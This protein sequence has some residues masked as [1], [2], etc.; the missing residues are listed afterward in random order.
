MSDLY[1]NL[2]A[3]A[4]KN[5]EVEL[6]G[7]VSSETLAR[8]FM[9]VLE[10][11]Q[12]EF[13][14]PGF[15]KGK[16]PIDVVRQNVHEHRLLEEAAEHALQEAY[17]AIVEE[18]K[19][20]VM[21]RPEVVI[22]K[23]AAGNP[24]EF[25]IR[26]GIRPDVK[27]PNYKKIAGKVLETEKP[28]E[29]SDKEL[30]EVILTLRKMRAAPASEG[31]S[32]PEEEKK[33]EDLPELTDEF[34]KTLG[35]FQTV[36]DFKTKLREN[37]R[38]EKESEN[39][40][41]LREKIAEAL[42]AEAKIELPPI[43]LEDEANRMFQDLMADLEHAKLSFEDYLKRAQKSEDDIKKEQRN[44]VERQLKMRFIL[45]GIAEAEHIA[46]KPEDIETETKLMADRYPDMDPERI[47]NYVT[48]LLKNEAVM[49][50]LEK[51]E[52]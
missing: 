10:D 5:S 7:E 33:T 51:K 27:L 23:L 26:V 19:L 4:P 31:A 50:L 41:A 40:T 6:T 30:E 13:E 18:K 9:A 20:D 35:D 49:Q 43:L 48:T 36:D 42:V 37:M 25:K 52:G 29:V 47:E 46:P 24:L 32:Q 21:G 11:V 44:Y 39:R 38:L 1:T 14:M 12:A 28:V 17:P 15:R 34:V 45:A 2:K 8:H 3:S 16:V 22:T